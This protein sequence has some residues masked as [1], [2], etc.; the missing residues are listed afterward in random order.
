MDNISPYAIS[1]MIGTGQVAGEFP[2]FGYVS[3]APSLDKESVSNW[4]KEFLE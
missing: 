4:K 3:L 1:S 2:L